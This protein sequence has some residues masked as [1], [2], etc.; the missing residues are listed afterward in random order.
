MHEVIVCEKPTS[1][2]KIAKAL[3]PSAKKK[4]YNKKVKYWELKKDSKDITVVSAVGH[5]YSLTPDNPKDK[6][7]FDLH[8]APAYEVNKKGSGFTKD[9]VRAIK[10]LG[11][12]ADSYVHA[13]DY[14]TEGTLIG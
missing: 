8:W 13:C 1:A 7:Y 9:Y 12:N 4:V 6:V 2:E 11:K 10:K 3:S 5:L 14:D